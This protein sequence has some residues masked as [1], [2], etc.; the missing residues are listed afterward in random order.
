MKTALFAGSFDPPTLGHLSLI[1]RA[2]KIFSK[3][4][5]GIALNETKEPLFS[6]EKRLEWLKEIVKPFPN[7][8]VISYSGLTIA[9]AQK[10]EVDVLLRGARNGSDFEREW[11]LAA[12]N[13]KLG[14]VETVIFPAD[15]LTAHISS[16]LIREILAS[17][18][19]LRGF[20]PDEVLNDLS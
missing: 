2:S 14:G 13:L 9:T 8:K 7:V 1:N 19:S 3:L 11:S 18:G 17:K 10:L 5:I 16:T 15:A 20:L 12:A 6:V 4:Y